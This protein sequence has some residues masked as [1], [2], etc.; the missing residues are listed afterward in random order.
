MTEKERYERHLCSR[1]WGLLTQGVRNRASNI[2]ERCH[3][4][5][6]DCVHH[7][8]YIRKYDELLT[9]LQGLCR[10]CHDFAHGRSNIDPCDAATK[11]NMR[12]REKRGRYC[13]AACGAYPM[14]MGKKKTITLPSPSEYRY[15]EAALE[16]LPADRKVSGVRIDFPCGHAF[17]LV[18]GPEKLA[19]THIHTY[20]GQLRYPNYINPDSA[21][22]FF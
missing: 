2:C 19:G 18:L 6:I 3:E 1:K 5:E 8:T 9:D 12:A 7:L 22:L 20:G 17:F 14:K 10:G 13:C 11:K 16:S 4:N 21:K 15:S